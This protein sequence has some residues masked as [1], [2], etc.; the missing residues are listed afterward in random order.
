MVEKCG[1]ALF[2]CVLIAVESSS[3]NAAVAFTRTLSI[4][5][6]EPASEWKNSVVAPRNCSRNPIRT[7]E[8]KRDKSLSSEHHGAS[9]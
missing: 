3:R 9:F 6:T 5:H 7:I 2:S 8:N 4:L 1:R